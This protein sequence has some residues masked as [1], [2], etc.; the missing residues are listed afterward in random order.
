MTRKQA[1]DGFLQGQRLLVCEYRSSKIESINWRDKSTGRAMEAKLLRHVI[2]AGPDSISVVERLPDDFKID[3][4][5]PPF[6]KGAPVVLR[7][8]EFSIDK[9]MLSARGSLESLAD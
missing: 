6:K 1:S 8:T 4:W 2:E 3:G 9:G 5:Q 7:Y